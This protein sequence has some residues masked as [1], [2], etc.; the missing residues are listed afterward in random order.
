MSTDSC[1]SPETISA[2]IKSCKRNS[3]KSFS[4]NGLNLSFFET[5]TNFVKP[6]KLN[7]DQ[8][9]KLQA[10]TKAETIRDREMRLSLMDIEDPEAYEQLVLGDSVKEYLNASEDDFRPQ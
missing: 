7:Q 8:E 1:F 10:E 2:I 3:V 5:D 6:K 4:F 9:A